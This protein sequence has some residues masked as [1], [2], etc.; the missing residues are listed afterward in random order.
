MKLCLHDWLADWHQLTSVFKWITTQQ[1]CYDVWCQDVDSGL[2]YKQYSDL[3]NCARYTS[4]SFQQTFQHLRYANTIVNG[5]T[6][7]QPA[8]SQ[9]MSS[10]NIHPTLQPHPLQP[11]PLWHPSALQPPSTSVMPDLVKFQ[12]LLLH[13]VWRH[14]HHA[15]VI[16]S[17]NIWQYWTST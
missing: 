14:Q 1:A 6:S 3:Q 5:P 15:R 9:P 12:W 10:N 7:L 8:P 13:Y 16:Q 11:A 4:N 17:D 2:V